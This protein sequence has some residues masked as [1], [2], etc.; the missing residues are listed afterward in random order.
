M[1]IF[2]NKAFNKWVSKEG[3]NDNL[4]RNAVTEIEQGL[5]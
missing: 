4:L 2:K 1:R 5:V 3:L